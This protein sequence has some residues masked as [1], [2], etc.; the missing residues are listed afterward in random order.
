M[1]IA[2]ERPQP[3]DTVR[4][5]GSNARQVRPSV[6]VEKWMY[7]IGGWSIVIA[8]AVGWDRGGSSLAS[9][10]SA[11]RRLTPTRLTRGLFNP[12]IRPIVPF[13]GVRGIRA[14]RTFSFCLLGLLA[15]PLFF[16]SVKL[17]C[18]TF[19]FGFR[20]RIIDACIPQGATVPTLRPLRIC[21]LCRP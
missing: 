20:L 21:R 18:S 8:R 9:T 1:K 15:H 5:F 14:G 17:C 19:E 13:L 10:S 3:H 11:V 16:F 12:E 7:G 6:L 2:D 4:N